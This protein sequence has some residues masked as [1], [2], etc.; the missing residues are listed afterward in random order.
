M[1]PGC[2]GAVTQ[3][4][5]IHPGGAVEVPWVTPAASALVLAVWREINHEAFPV[6]IISGQLYCG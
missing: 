1:Q 5:I 4:L 3:E 6:N 2:P